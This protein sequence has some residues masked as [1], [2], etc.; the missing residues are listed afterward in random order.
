MSTTTKFLGQILFHGLNGCF[1][2]LI[3]LYIDN[4]EVGTNM[5]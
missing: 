2:F 4:V 3:E 1:G 5:G